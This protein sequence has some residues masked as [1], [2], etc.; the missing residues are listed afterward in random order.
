MTLVDAFLLFWTGDPYAQLKQLN[1]I[2]REV[3]NPD[4]KKQMLRPG[5]QVRE[6]ELL[7]FVALIILL[8]H[9]IIFTDGDCGHG[10]ASQKNLFNSTRFW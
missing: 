4:R 3:V 7:T 10:E 6:E 5:S 9:N 2:L 8:R 1:R